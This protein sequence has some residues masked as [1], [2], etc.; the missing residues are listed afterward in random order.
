MIA[1]CVS[2]LSAGPSLSEW[3]CQLFYGTPASEDDRR[4]DRE[5]EAKY[6]ARRAE[7]A[8]LVK[9]GG[10]VAAIYGGAVDHPSR[11]RDVDVGYLGMS[12]GRAR[13]LASDWAANHS[14]GGLP[15]ETHQLQLADDGVWFR[16]Y[17]KRQRSVVIHGETPVRARVNPEGVAGAIR[18]AILEGGNIPSLRAVGA[19][20]R[21]DV[22]VLVAL[23]KEDGATARALLA[24]PPKDRASWVARLCAAYSEVRHTALPCETAELRAAVAVVAESHAAEARARAAADGQVMCAMT[25]SMAA[26]GGD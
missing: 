23:S 7:L 8:S 17:S 3:I 11:A 15:V 18:A 14:M 9:D 2:V 26:I 20:R 12:E 1:S 25:A 21:E 22:A 5:R 19:D 4:A 16:A 10:G 13:A 6:A 24:L